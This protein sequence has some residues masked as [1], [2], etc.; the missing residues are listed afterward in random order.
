MNDSNLPHQSQDRFGR[1]GTR[2]S[3]P[4]QSHPC[5]PPTYGPSGLS[6]KW[7]AARAT[8][9][10]SILHDSELRG[11]DRT[12]D[13]WIEQLSASERPVGPFGSSSP[14]SR[15]RHSTTIC[16]TAGGEEGNSCSQAFVSL[17]TRQYAQ[18]ASQWIAASAAT[19][20]STRP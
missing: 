4:D 16:G 1:R 15:G 7:S 3:S 17:T 8:W 13:W 2:A 9:P 14:R 6:C 10:C 20:S 12:D 5:D 19:G 11:C 18:L